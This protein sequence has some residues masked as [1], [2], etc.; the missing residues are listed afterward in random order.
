M[1]IHPNGSQPAAVSGSAIY[2]DTENLRDSEHAQTVVA[3]V[4]ANWPTSRP[5]LSGLSLYVRADRVASWEMWAETSYPDLRVRVRGVQHFSSNKA[6]NSA[7]LAITADAVADLVTGQAVTIAVV[8]ND[9]D[10][11]ALFVKVKELA[12]S[13]GVE[14][15]PFLWITSPEAGGLSAELERFIP[16]SLRW[17]LSETPL[18]ASAAPREISQPKP[19]SLPK[20]ERPAAL[21][22]GAADEP[23]DGNESI[24]EE[25]IRKLPIGKFKAADAQQVFKARWP[26]RPIANADTAKFGQFF[27]NQIWP[28]L[29]EHGVLMTR[30]SSPRTYEITPTA[31]SAVSQP[32]PAKTMPPPSEPNGPEFTLPQLAAAVAAGIA[33]EV[34]SATHAL[35][36][37]KD[38]HPEHPA[39]SYPAAQF[40]TWFAKQIWPIMEQHG[41]TIAKE[42]PR[43]Y[44]MTPDARHN[45]TALA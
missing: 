37:L 20:R 21:P 9:S 13:V 43:R 11:G 5:P 10:F 31:K 42:K 45:L 36:A 23:A 40:G 14:R 3:Q 16:A 18:D 27:G 24:A 34:F 1:T 7:D 8:S 33:D 4:V 15:P 26:K 19:P 38:R 29:Q 25:L 12:H 30:K 2:V 39:A 28:I 17:D 41:V 32:P 22:A 44:E 6:K 35:A